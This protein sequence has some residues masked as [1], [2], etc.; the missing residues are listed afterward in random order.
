LDVTTLTFG[1]AASLEVRAPWPE[2]DTRHIA[3]L[4]LLSDGTLLAASASDPGNDGPFSSA[5]YI[6][7]TLRPAADRPELAAAQP[8]TRLFTTTTHKIE[9]IE[10][11]PGPRGGLVIGSDDE[12]AGGAIFLS[13]YAPTPSLAD[14]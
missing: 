3:D 12:N 14:G 13:W 6:A 7:G 1:E 9:A 11:V 8:I 4:R 2:S 5:V 10:L